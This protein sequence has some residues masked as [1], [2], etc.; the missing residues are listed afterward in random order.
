[1]KCS[2]I[3]SHTPVGLKLI[4]SSLDILHNTIPILIICA[5]LMG[6]TSSSGSCTLVAG[7]MY[8]LHCNLQFLLFL[9]PGLS[10]L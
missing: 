6:R 8:D 2:H 7:W 3:V 10:V 1:M 4:G 5:S 9:L